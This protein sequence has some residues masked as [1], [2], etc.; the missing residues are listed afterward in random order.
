MWSRV[1]TAASSRIFIYFTWTYACLLIPTLALKFTYLR[2]KEVRED[3]FGE[4]W[5]AA[6]YGGGGLPALERLF[7]SFRSDILEV[8]VWYSNLGWYYKQRNRF[9]FSS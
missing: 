3:E 5:H 1:R 2:V 8:L 9:Y 7:L 6:V 4:I